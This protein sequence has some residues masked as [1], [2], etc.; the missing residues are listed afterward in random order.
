[1]TLPDVDSDA[2]SRCQG[3]ERVSHHVDMHTSWLIGAGQVPKHHV[4]DARKAD[5]WVL[6][7]K[8]ILLVAV[9]SRSGNGA[10]AASRPESI[11]ST[12]YSLL[13]LISNPVAVRKIHRVTRYIY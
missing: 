12:A 2:A 11:D 4:I 7:A 3:N 1:M 8:R 13:V 6:Q 9:A 10:A 5:R